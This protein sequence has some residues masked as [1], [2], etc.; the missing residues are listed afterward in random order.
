MQFFAKK[1]VFLFL[2]AQ[3]FNSIYGN[4]NILA[5]DYGHKRIGLAYGDS[6]IGVAVP[7]KAAG[8]N[9]AEERLARIKSEI[10]TRKIDKLVLGYPLN[11][12][13]TKSKKAGEVDE[14]AAVLERVFALP[15][16]RVDERLSSYQAESD[17]AA[18]A[19]KKTKTI[20]ARQKTRRS[21][22]VDS[23]AAALFLQ[24]YLDSGGEIAPGEFGE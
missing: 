24:E 11:M 18:F 2:T 17:M 14:F 16:A 19:P 1:C 3:K 20:R 21:G 9:S 13:G 10:E 4:M 15:I 8:E 12:D 22:E 23:R 6:E 5:I 7:I